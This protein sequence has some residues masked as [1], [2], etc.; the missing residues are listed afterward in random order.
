MIR[1]RNMTLA[2]VLAAALAGGGALAQSPEPVSADRAEVLAKREAAMKAMGGAM[3]TIG[4][5]VKN[6]GGTIEQVREQAATLER[7]SATIA[8]NLFPAG[9]GADEGDSDALPVIWE[10][11]SDFEAAA[12]RL[13][14][15]SAELSKVAEGNDRAA[16]ARQ[17]AAVG[18]SCGGCHEQFRAKKN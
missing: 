1:M 16:V 12:G 8:P 18:Q 17:F 3:K 6:E 9:T 5:Y 13:E 11:W 2:A 4:A 10:R 7:N 14:T 15:A